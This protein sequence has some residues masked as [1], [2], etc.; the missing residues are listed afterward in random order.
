MWTNPA[1]M[2]ESKELAAPKLSEPAWEV[3]ARKFRL[4]AELKFR[5]GK[6]SWGM[7]DESR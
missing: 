7:S 2:S 5:N 3:E 1:E 6:S 4:M